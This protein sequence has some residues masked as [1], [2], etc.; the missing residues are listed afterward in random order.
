MEKVVS[1]VLGLLVLIS[2]VASGQAAG[3]RL[4][5]RYAENFS[6]EE[7][8]S[9]RIV[10]VRNPWRGDRVTRYSSTR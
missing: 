3:E 2:L 4:D 1:R 7:F 8:E 9:Y 5:L 10:A 6:I